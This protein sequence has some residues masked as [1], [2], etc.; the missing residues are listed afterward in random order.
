MVDESRHVV[1]PGE[2]TEIPPEVYDI[3]FGW[4][5]QSE[6]ARLLFAAREAG[7]EPRS[8][9]E[10]G[11]G[12]GRM[13]RTLAP[14]ITDRAGLDLSPS[15]A[16]F[17]AEHAAGAAV[18]RADMSAFALGRHFDLIYATANSLRYVTDAPAVS[19]MWQRIAEHLAPGGVFIA[20]LELGFEAEAG[21]LNK[22][23]VWSASR[24]ETEVRV[25]WT[26]TRP[27]DRETRCCDVTWR[28]ER[29]TRGRGPEAWSETFSLR[30]YDAGELAAWMAGGGVQVRAFYEIRDPYLLERSMERAVGRML[31][32]A[33]R[34][35]QHAIE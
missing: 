32:V 24:G 12:S 21:K 9:L 17:A 33:T 20:D 30:T 10:L 22:P 2:A 35:G 5:P 1:A 26:V 27:P 34:A 19:R 4:D 23:A 14:H 25:A 16:D 29:R 13:L 7:C 3:G 8:A 11:C 31:V 18:H 6:V 28:F 15:M